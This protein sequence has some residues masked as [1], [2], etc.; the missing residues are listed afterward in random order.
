MTRM[1]R[2]AR[3]F[4]MARVVCLLLL[5]ALIPLRLADPR[6]LEELRLRTFDMFQVLRPRVQDG[7][8]VVIVDID[9][10]SL[11]TIGQWP[12]PR[13]IIAD[14]V[15]RITQSGPAAIGFDVVFAEPDRM[16][17]AIAEQSFV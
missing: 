10:D 13:T 8:P 7:Y 14:L 9:E 12:W 1:A 2:W 15:N 3:Q 4:G 5:F 11:K 6:P 16:S 17:P